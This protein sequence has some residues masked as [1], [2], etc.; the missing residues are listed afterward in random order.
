MANMTFKASLL[1]NTD[2]G[3]SLGSSSKKWNIYGNLTGN[4]ST[5]DKWKTARTLTIGNT[6]KSVD[7][8]ANVSWT[9]AEILGSG[10]T[11][12]FYRGDNT[13]SNTLTDDLNITKAGECG[14]EVN[15]TQSTNPNQVAFIV[16]S[17]GNA[18]IYSRKNSKWIVYN[19]S[20]DRTYLA[21]SYNGAATALAYSQAGLAASAITWLTCWNGYELRAISKAE[22]A[23]AVD[24]AHKWVRISGDTMT[25]NL[26]M[27]GS[28][29]IFNWQN[30]TRAA[31]TIYTLGTLSFK[32]AAN[33]ATYSA[34]WLRFIGTDGTDGY[35]TTV[36]YGSTNGTTWI[37]AGE[38]GSTLPTKLAKYNDENIY[39]GCDGQ[40]SI[41]TGSA[42]DASNYKLTFEARANG[43]VYTTRTYGAVWND[44]A[45]CREVK[46]DIAPGKC[47]R[48]VGDGT[49]IPTTAR[50]QRGCN[51]VSDTFGFA[52]GE[53]ERYKTPIAVSG[54]VLAY[55][56]E[57]RELA[58]QRIGYGV[59]SGPDGTVSIMTEE[60][61]RMYPNMI[62]GTISEVPDYEIW[63]AGSESNSTEIK[64]NGRIW[65]RVR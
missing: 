19:T 43:Y 7:G 53:T 21:D 51:I 17:S 58:R 33:S 4:A 45:E 56:Y 35:N 62:V 61:E 49:L 55:L 46:E 63:H 6:G 15:N 31:N 26:T 11:A 50:L 42:N 57:D 10:T 9:K 52:I 2:L 48:E 18:G 29:I 25:G 40:V 34:P 27:S 8:S 47:V 28:Q 22:T 59:C 24:S 41:Y 44:Y 32:N 12:Q 1:P 30:A 14:V 5:A 16:G 13:W 38:S 3:Y 37:T 39:L 23:N 65:I 60:E 20:A 54:R 36:M 64:V